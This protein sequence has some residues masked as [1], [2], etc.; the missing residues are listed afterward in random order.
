MG[1]NPIQ[2]GPKL[3][4]G[5]H[6]GMIQNSLKIKKKQKKKKTKQKTKQKMKKKTNK[7]TQKQMLR[8]DHVHAMQHWIKKQAKRARYQEE[9]G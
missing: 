7:K 8:G 1:K 3:W 4:V 9:Y 6:L 5:A 2:S